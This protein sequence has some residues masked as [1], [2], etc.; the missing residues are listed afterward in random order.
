M[1]DKEPNLGVIDP[2]QVPEHH[3]AG[4]YRSL[5]ISR[6]LQIL[7]NLFKATFL[8]YHPDETCAT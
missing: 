5:N 2:E 1:S 4:L 7:N 3:M 6:F 8:H